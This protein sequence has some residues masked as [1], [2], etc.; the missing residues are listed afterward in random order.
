VKS[1]DYNFLKRVISE[2]ELDRLE[3]QIFDAIEYSIDAYERVEGKDSIRKDRKKEAL[4]IG[5]M[6]DNYLSGLCVQLRAIMAKE[7]VDEEGLASL[8]HFEDV[9]PEELRAHYEQEMIML[10]KEEQEQKKDKQKKQN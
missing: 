9:T 3:L 1:E 7:R 10:L 4:I 2:N 5:A 8:I 6:R